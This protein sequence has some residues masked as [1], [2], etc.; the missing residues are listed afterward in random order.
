MPRPSILGK[1]CHIGLKFKTS[2]Y[3]KLYS[4]YSFT[5][6][7]KSQATLFF[8]A[9]AVNRANMILLFENLQE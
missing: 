6:A 7:K 1:S 9:P 3:N 2:E 8:V 5:C 4:K